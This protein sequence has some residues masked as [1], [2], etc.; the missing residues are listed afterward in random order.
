VEN[1]SYRAAT[2]ELT[3]QVAAVQA[4]VDQLSADAQLD[5]SSARALARLPASVRAGA[6]GGGAVDSP[7]ARSVMSPA[8]A[9]PEDTFGP[10]REWLGRLGSRLQVVRNDVEKRAALVAATPSIWPAY[11]GL[12]ATFGQRQDPFTGS[13]A[14][15]TGIDISADKGR[16]VFATA[17]GTVVSAGWNGDYGTMVV[18]D[19][20]FGIV[21]RYGHLSGCAVQ[22]GARVDRNQVIGYVGATGRATGPHLHYEMLVNGQLTNP[23]RFLTDTRRP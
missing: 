15:H 2:K 20:G 4:F 22:A 3:D 21:T 19:H 1:N 5:P 7:I 10:L 12:S 23:L 6:M 13:L 14:Q 8:L 9:L 16:P 17:A 11:G 18:I